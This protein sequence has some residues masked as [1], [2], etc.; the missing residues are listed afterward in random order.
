M[1]LVN[2]I[3]ENKLALLFLILFSSIILLVIT[4]LTALYFMRKTE[5][6][7]MLIYYTK[8]LV[9]VLSNN[10][11]IFS[12]KRIMTWIAF[13]S[14]VGAEL[15]YYFIH[16]KTMDGMTAGTH[17]GILLGAAMYATRMVQKEKETNINANGK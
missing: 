11:S 16:I 5:F 1:E 10:T 3:L 9:K 6:G 8:E 4:W 13:L 17:T 14:G 2:K 15:C 7:K 12:S